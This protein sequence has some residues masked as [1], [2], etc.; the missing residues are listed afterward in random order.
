MNTLASNLK[1]RNKTPQQNSK[2]NLLPVLVDY[3][4]LRVPSHIPQHKLSK[5]CFHAA[6]CAQLCLKAP[7]CVEVRLLSLCLISLSVP[8]M[9]CYLQ[10]WGCL[11]PEPGDH[12]ET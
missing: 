7:G 1:K 5:W 8:D 9:T 12:T 6:L 4:P 11:G 10:E 3:L 2:G